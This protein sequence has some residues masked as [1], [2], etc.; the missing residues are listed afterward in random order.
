MFFFAA[1]AE[2]RESGLTAFWR[3]C[4]SSVVISVHGEC[5]CDLFASL[6]SPLALRIEA[7]PASLPLFL[8]SILLRV[9]LINVGSGEKGALV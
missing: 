2:E 7:T 3:E 1:V 8:N 4:V 5:A 9:S 6:P